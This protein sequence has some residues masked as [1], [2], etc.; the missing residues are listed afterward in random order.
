[1]KKLYWL[2]S[3]WRIA[4]VAVVAMSYQLV[5]ANQWGTP[6][7][8]VSTGAVG[9]FASLAVVNGNP[10][11]SYFV[12]G[13][14]DLAYVRA[15]NAE[16]TAWGT[17]VVVEATGNVGRYTS[18]AVVDGNPAIAYRDNTG[19][20]LKYVRATNANGT[21]WGTPVSFGA[22]TGG[23][24]A[25]LALVD[26]HP[27]IAY[28]DSTFQQLFY[29][30]AN[31][32]TGTTWGTP[33]LLEA[34]APNGTGV[35]V[36][37]LVVDGNPAVTYHNVDAGDLRYRRATN[38]QGTAWGAAVVV[39][40]G[41]PIEPDMA[42]I[43]GRPAISYAGLVGADRNIFYVRAND[44]AGTT[45]GT[46]QQIAVDGRFTSLTTVATHPAVAYQDIVPPQN[47][48]Y[49]RA[50]DVNGTT[51]GANLVVDSSANNTGRYAQLEIV[52]GHPAI[53]YRDETLED[54]MYV[55]SPNPTAVTLSGQG[56]AVPVQSFYWLGW[57]VLLLGGTW[58]V[59][60]ARPR[61]LKM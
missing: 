33:V 4:V 31:D 21:A 30:R 41:A 3:V 37:L 35:Y 36:K 55:R 10:A 13:D 47:L 34:S 25:S 59:W 40:T 60:R 57:V 2:N 6:Q 15:T 50:L 5:Y 1:M 23:Y 54:L 43:N 19:G 27:A 52:A 46:P 22:G 18:L 48:H 11:M 14:S 49:I 58:W 44:T 38:A 53:A 20:T 26:G 24:D 28:V 61:T 9:Q 17:P 42:I 56:T 39:A 7:T 29:V 32:A 51:W 16:G 45:W 12:G 8:V